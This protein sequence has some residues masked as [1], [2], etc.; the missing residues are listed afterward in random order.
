MPCYA[1][2]PEVLLFLALTSYCES[3]TLT[4]VSRRLILPAREITGEYGFMRT[5]TT[6]DYLFV[7]RMAS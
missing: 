2:G 7:D 5:F 1:S 6:F 4:I 3:S